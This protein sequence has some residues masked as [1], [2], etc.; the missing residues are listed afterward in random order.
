MAGCIVVDI[1]VTNPDEF[2]KYALQAKVLE[3]RTANRGVTSP[4]GLPA[5][6][7]V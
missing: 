1:E 6:S 3:R 2:Q 5:L 4:S 7:P